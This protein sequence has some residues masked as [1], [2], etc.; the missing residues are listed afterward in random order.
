MLSRPIQAGSP[1][2]MIKTEQHEIW[3]ASRVLIMEKIVKIVHVDIDGEDGVIVNFS[4]DTTTAYA[5]EELLTLRPYR[6][7][8]KRPVKIA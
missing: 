6:D 7:P 1:S 4:D 2:P 3:L 8:L 5:T